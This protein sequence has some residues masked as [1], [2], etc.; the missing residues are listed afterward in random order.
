MSGPRRALTDSTACLGFRHYPALRST[1]CGLAFPGQFP[2]LRHAWRSP[3]IRQH[4]QR[5]KRSG[6]PS[7]IGCCIAP[8]VYLPRQTLTCRCPI[9][10][11]MVWDQFEFAQVAKQLTIAGRKYCTSYSDSN[12]GHD[13]RLNSVR[14]SYRCCLQFP[15][16]LPRN[17]AGSNFPMA[18]ESRGN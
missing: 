16:E 4:R 5:A 2:L 18:T 12:R 1:A 6:L 7:A 11:N 8:T 15:K 17:A 10:V 14:R 13:R 3:D 9:T